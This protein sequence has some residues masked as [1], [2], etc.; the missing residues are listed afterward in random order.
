MKILSVDTSAGYACAALAEDTV[1][2]HETC[3][4]SGRAHSQTLLP[5]I[6]QMLS[7]HGLRPHDLDLC[8][9]SLGPG[10]Y[11]GIR[12]GV[13]T[14]KGLLSGSGIPVVPV[15][16]L[17]ALASGCRFFDGVICPVIDARRDQMYT[18]LF[19]CKN[20]ELTRMTPD[21]VLLLSELDRLLKKTG[22]VV[23]PVG[24]GYEKALQKLTYGKLKPL[25][26]E[27]RHT[28]AFGAALAG[29]RAYLRDPSLAVDESLLLPRY[30]KATQAER[31]LEERKKAKGT[32][33]I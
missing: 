1:L 4:L 27:H 6:A 14:V 19:S 20:G 29:Y 28:R 17:E 2:L 16:S 23:L 15:S 18:A 7:L 31:E 10:S 11:T 24:D 33:S 12:I 9:C 5:M 32:K 22:R 30:L 26:E 3:D 13:A 8:V 25:P 21:G